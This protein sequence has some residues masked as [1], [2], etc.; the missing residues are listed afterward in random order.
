MSYSS[1]FFLYAPV[2]LVVLIAAG[3]SFHWSRTATAFEAKLAALKGHEAIPGVTLDW[4]KA[5]VSGFPFRIDAVFENFAAHG[6]GPHGP[7][8]WQSRHFA[9]HGLTY[10]AQKDVFEAAGV[11]HL[12]WTDAADQRHSFS[13]EAGSLHA[14]AVRNA[15]GLAR[16]D[17][18]AVQLVGQGLTMGRAQFHM[19]RGADGSTIDMMVS[20][21]VLKGEMGFSA[22]RSAP[23]A[24]TRRCMAPR[25]MPR[26]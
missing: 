16:F 22:I 17:V 24:S 7:F 4:S 14:S 18:D 5:E 26:C 20:G 11:Q 1:R 23:C 21:D 6:Q 19:R 13:F 12:E 8:R 3:V 2:A 15:S 9:L 25:P 10:G